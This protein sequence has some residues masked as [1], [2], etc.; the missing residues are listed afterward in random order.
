MCVCV[1]Q[2]DLPQNCDNTDK[3]ETHWNDLILA[4]QSFDFI[5]CSHIFM[6][7]ARKQA[8]K[9]GIRIGL[10]NKVEN[11]LQQP[12]NGLNQHKIFMK[13]CL[14]RKKA[15]HANF[16]DGPINVPFV[17]LD[18]WFMHSCVCVCLC[19]S[20]SRSWLKISVY[21][22]H[23]FLHFIVVKNDLEL[24]RLSQKLFELWLKKSKH[25]DFR[26]TIQ[27]LMPFFFLFV[28]F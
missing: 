1:S 26:L 21:W 17:V 25:F 22:T 10:L 19:F 28:I 11:S 12:N 20:L 13:L 4:K 23:R 15:K 8:H 2:F 9:M 7:S 3:T 27:R 24:K 6:I 5:R 16:K 18:L 14:N